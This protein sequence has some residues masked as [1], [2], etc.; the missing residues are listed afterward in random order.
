MMN[1]SVSATKYSP[2]G[3]LETQN[4]QKQISK[5]L[6]Q[7]DFL[8]QNHSNE[9]IEEF[10]NQNW[11]A[12]TPDKKSIIQQYFNAE[13]SNAYSSGKQQSNRVKEMIIKIFDVN[14]IKSI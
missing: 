5:D 6:Y 1:E 9:L 3:Y 11:N 4:E 13:I 8:P 12:T 10:N 7:P 14:S 2:V